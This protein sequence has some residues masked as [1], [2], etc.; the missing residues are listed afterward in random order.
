[1]DVIDLAKI[2]PEMIRLVGGKAAGLGA[3]A[4]AGERVPAGFCLTT[5]AY[6]AGLVPEDAVIAAYRGLGRGPVAV[7]S[8]ST[9]E[10]L[11][12]ASFAGQ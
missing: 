5:E 10:D 9:A 7:R 1:M 8:S 2:T 12:E 4:A 11:P 3:M 6:R